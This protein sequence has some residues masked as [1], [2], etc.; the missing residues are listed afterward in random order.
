MS[1]SY[2]L[3][4]QP[5]FAGLMTSVKGTTSESSDLFISHAIIKAAHLYLFI[6]YEVIFFYGNLQEKG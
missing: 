6:S 1:K 3:A 5:V 2:S 4:G